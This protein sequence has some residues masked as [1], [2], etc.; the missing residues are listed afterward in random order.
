MAICL[1]YKICSHNFSN[2]FELSKQDKN[3][4]P[5]GHEVLLDDLR[6]LVVSQVLKLLERPK[7][8]LKYPFINRRTAIAGAIIGILLFI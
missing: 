6:W 5:S 8:K 4:K 1:F 3:A 7:I 2:Y